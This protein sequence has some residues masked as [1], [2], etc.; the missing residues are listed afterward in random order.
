MANEVA[1]KEK[2]IATYLAIPEVRESIVNVLGKT[3]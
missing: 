2:G 1:I 3:M